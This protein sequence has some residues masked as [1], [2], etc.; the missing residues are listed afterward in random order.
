MSK[1]ALQWSSPDQH[2]QN[3]VNSLKT[4]CQK[5]TECYFILFCLVLFIE[6]HKRSKS[7]GS[8]FT[9]KIFG[10]RVVKQNTVFSIA[11]NATLW[12]VIKKLH[13]FSSLLANIK[14]L[15]FLVLLILL[16]ILFLLILWMAVCIKDNFLLWT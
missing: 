6:R 15:P 13:V 5:K 16:E 10:Y 12:I 8:K 7:F 9:K 4:S 11:K 3:L 1:G 2:F 14:N